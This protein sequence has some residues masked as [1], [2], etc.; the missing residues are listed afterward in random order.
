MGRLWLAVLLL[1]GCLSARAASPLPEPIEADWLVP[2]FRFHDGSH[3]EQMRLH[4]TTLGNPANPAVLVLHGTLGT[5]RGLLTPMFGE[6]LFGPGQ[7]LDA[8]HHFIILPDGIGAGSSAKPSDGLRARFPRYNYDDCVEAQYRLVTE[9]LGISHLQAVIGYSM[10]GMQAW[11]WAGQ[12]PAQMDVVVALAA[13]PMAMSGRNWMMR[14]LVIDAIRN[15]PEWQGGNYTQQPRSLQFASVFFGL[16]TVP[17]TLQLAQEAPDHAASD[18]WLDKR[19]QAPF[20]GD[21]NDHLYQ[22]DASRDFDP[23]PTL[24]KVRARLLAVNSADDPRNPPELAVMERVIATLPQADFLLIPGSA[25]TTGH[26]TTLDASLWRAR[27]AR[28]LQG[29]QGA[30]VP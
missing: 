1:A 4:Y 16:A 25:S 20:K 8:E 15:D 10:G 19:L 2:D 21:A 9:H 11:L 7:A 30:T 6:A 22:W 23:V 27:L 17:G 28:Q 5:G 13:T 18:A 29:L 3:L 24:G 26:A 14:R 12:H